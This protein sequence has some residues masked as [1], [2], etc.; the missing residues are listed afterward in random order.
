MNEC[1]AIWRSILSQLEVMISTIS[2]DL[3]F[4]DLVPYTI[5]NDVLILVA[6]LNSF[7]KVPVQYADQIEA[8]IKASGSKVSGIEIITENEKDSFAPT[9]TVED[10]PVQ[11][12]ESVNVFN[13]DYTFDS[14]VVGDNNAL[15]VAAA[16]SVAEQPG[17]NHNPL[18]IYGGVGL[19]KT[20]IIDRK[21]TRL[22]SSHPK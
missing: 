14:F 11:D 20:H 18:F 5:E 17:K 19:G 9:E 6:P 1:K 4:K 16:K 8:A 12:E 21:S 3:W 13:P 15:A 2:F 22:N 10:K 7:K